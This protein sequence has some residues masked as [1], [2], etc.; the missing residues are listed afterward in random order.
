[1]D[2]T[3]G[4]SIERIEKDEAGNLW[5]CTSGQ[6]VYI[7]NENSFRNTLWNLDGQTH[8]G[9]ANKFWIAKSPGELN[10]YENGHFLRLEGSDQQAIIDPVLEDRNQN[11]WMG[12]YRGLAKYDGQNIT[13][14]RIET[15]QS[16]FATRAITEDHAGN[17]W[18][19]RN[20]GVIVKYDGA[21]FIQYG[22]QDG[23]PPNNF[24]YS[25]EDKQHNLWFS[26][27][28][29]GLVKF[30]GVSFTVL[31]EKEGL[32]SNHIISMAEDQ[33]GNI[34]LG[35]KGQGLMKYDGTYFTYYTENEGL[36]DNVVTSIAVDPKNQIWA[37][38]S[39]GLNVLI[40]KSDQ[41][42]PNKNESPTEAWI[43]NEYTIYSF[44]KKDGL[45]D[46]LI[47]WNVLSVDEDS[48]LWGMQPGGV[49]K[50][51]INHFELPQAP[52]SVQLDHLD[53]NG[54]AIDFCNAKENLPPGLDYTE[55]PPF[56]N[57]PS[58]PVFLY[59]NDHLTFHYSA[60][61]WSAPHK[62]LYS[63]RMVASDGA[64]SVP[65]SDTKADFR[66]LTAGLYRFEVRAMGQSQKWSEPF[67][68]TF[69]ILPPWWKTWWAYTI[70]LILMAGLVYRLYR[71]Q[72]RRQLQKQ[73][74][75]NLKA[76][77]AFKNELYT[78]ITHEFRTPLTII[79]GMIDQISE[80]PDLW[81]ERGAK[82]IKQNTAGLLSLINQ[83]LD[84]RKLESKEIKVQMVNGNV[85]KYLRYISESHQSYAEH[86]NLQLH[87]LT[88]EEKVNMDYDPDKLLRIIS[89]LLSNAIKFTPEGGHVYLHVDQK[90]LD[91]K[92]ALHL[93]VQDTGAGIPEKDLPYI[94]GRFYQAEQ[95]S[96]RKMASS[97]IGLALVQELVKVLGGNIHVKSTLG[98][99][100]TFTIELPIT[101]ESLLPAENVSGTSSAVEKP[102]IESTPIQTAIVESSTE[103][104]T[105]GKP[106]LLIVE[107]NPDV[108]Q[109]LIACLQEAYQLTLAENGQIGINKAIELIPDLIVSDVMMPEKDGYELTEL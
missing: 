86:S 51:D 58:N 104:G 80:K 37:G 62:I 46:N 73:E 38:T 85:V 72:L 17:I 18:L 3:K 9:K 25:I 14:Y 1:L 21:Q 89:N 8:K 22:A 15:N 48:V 35:T 7:L 56:F 99:G 82:M 52:I 63:F 87:F 79:S 43:Q 27:E 96:I 108:R 50:L 57:Y 13:Y 54:R 65:S 2:E 106:H 19:A 53:I 36:S 59:K 107:D 55:V 33:K 97:G 67:T 81:L 84:L 90:I 103:P 47:G 30:D 45:T 95:P 16:L 78:N 31:S 11:I 29:G 68:Y 61:D 69:R 83:M 105:A 23:I 34:W 49:F 102:L 12:L 109:Y 71:Y 60:T 4:S 24:S 91:G 75:E 42:T 39:S 32:S 88:A 64:W 20:N 101:N 74:L 70:Y 98:K 93:R 77:D 76:I 41:E 100:S 10:K 40:P 6:G 26:S 92:P 66:N 44:S 94:F 28:G 5:F